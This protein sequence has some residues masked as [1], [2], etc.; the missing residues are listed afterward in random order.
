MI[1]ELP[2]LGVGIG[3]RQELSEGIFMNASAI[4]FIELLTDQFID[5]PAYRAD[6]AR[7]VAAAFPVVLHGVE[8]SLG[9]DAPIDSDYL[10]KV[11]EI[12]DWVDP[13]W[14]SDHLSFT[15]VPELSIGQLTPLSFNESVADLTARNVR[16]AA[17]TFDCPFLI[18][19]ISYYF[20]VPPCTLTE[21]EFITAVLEKADCGLLLD[22]TNVQ[23]N[24]LN[25]EYDAHEFLDEIPLERVVQVH[26]AGGRSHQGL[27]L[28]TH[29]DPVPEEVFELLDYTV[30]RMTELRGISI[31][32]DQECSGIEELLPE[33]RRAR[34]SA[35]SR[36]IAADT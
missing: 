33:L 25:N 6:E 3:Y 1:D 16:A 22:L 29:S 5:M 32:R 15:R 23:N 2:N 7:R 9:T 34:E 31:E 10:A 19:N 8:L 24:A 36:A 17:G 4:D 14:V 11:H 26:L 27:L 13:V 21:A 30:P 12:A 20:Q 28:D 35:S 18:E